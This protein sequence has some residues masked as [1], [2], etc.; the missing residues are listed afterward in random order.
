MT[1]EQK[2]KAYDEILVKAMELKEANPSDEGIQRWLYDT[3]PNLAESE[4]ERIRKIITLC[5]EECVHSDIIRDY[6]KDNAIDWLKSLN[7]RYT[8][9][10]SDEQMKILFIYADQ[11]NSH[12]TVLTSLYQELRKLKE[13]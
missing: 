10:P 2:A 8:W 11:N 3:F 12:G 9:K 13:E 5:L 1:T 6:E 4:D 7:G